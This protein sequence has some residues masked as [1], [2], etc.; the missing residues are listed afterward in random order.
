MAVVSGMR[1]SALL[2]IRAVFECGSAATCHTISSKMTSPSTLETHCLRKRK[3]TV[4]ALT[5]KPGINWLWTPGSDVTKLI[6][7]ETF[8]LFRRSRGI[9]AGM[10]YTVLIRTFSSK[11]SKLTTAETS[12]RIRI[13]PIIAEIKKRLQEEERRETKKKKKKHWY[14]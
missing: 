7:F 13:F 1:L 12:Q 8:H 11:V 5:R 14:S 6:A 3:R 9:V 2:R 10:H 4:N